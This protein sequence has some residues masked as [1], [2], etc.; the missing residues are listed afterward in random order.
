MNK[1]NITAAKSLINNA[2]NIVVTAHK[3][4]DGDAVGSAL[5]LYHY[6]KKQRKKRFGYPA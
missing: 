3:N 6:L 4:P 2:T 1:V 5:A